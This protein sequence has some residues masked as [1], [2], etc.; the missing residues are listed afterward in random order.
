MEIWKDVI[1]YEGIYQVSS[2]G[3]VKRVAG[4]HGATP[5]RVLKPI[6]H[7]NGY[8]QVCLYRDKKVSRKYVHRLVLEAHVGPAPEGCEGNHKSGDK[9][10]NRIGNLGWVTRSENNKHAYRVLGREPTIAPPRGEAHGQS[11]L[12]DEDVIEIRELWATGKYLQRELAEMFGVTRQTI[13]KIVNRRLWR[14]VA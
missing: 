3:R 7:P 13:G 2:L 11:K 5:G 6:K 10:D 12:A 1:G 4:G 8:L 14:H 9:T